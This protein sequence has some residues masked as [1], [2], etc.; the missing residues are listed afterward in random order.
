[1]VRTCESQI[2][3]CEVSVGTTRTRV[4]STPGSGPPIVLLH[5]FGDSA[6]TWR[7]VL[8]LL[9]AAGHVAV[10]PDLPG[11]GRAPRL[12]R[13]QLLP[14]WDA[15][16]LEWIDGRTMSNADFARLGEPLDRKSVV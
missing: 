6:D 11:F 1:M 14:Q 2:E 13:E 10:A 8:E 12:Q 16:V 4:L 7:P 3:E 9:A 15:F 5:G